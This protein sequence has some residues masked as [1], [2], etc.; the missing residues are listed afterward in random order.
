HRGGGDLPGVQLGGDGAPAHCPGILPT[1]PYTP[2]SSSGLTRGSST[3]ACSRPTVEQTDNWIVGSSPRMTAW[4]KEGRGSRPLMSQA[5]A[6]SELRH[7][8]RATRAGLQPHHA[9]QVREG[10][11]QP[12]PVGVFRPARLAVAVI[13]LEVAV[14]IPLADHQR[15]QVAVDV[16]E[17]GQ[18]QED[19]AAE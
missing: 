3:A 7:R 9:Q 18:A 1:V 10:R 15:R 13:D 14:L 19:V 8:P 11:A 16:I 4:W 12:A 17:V 2:P 5:A 6:A